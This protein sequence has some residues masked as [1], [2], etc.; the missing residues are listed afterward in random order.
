M[1][2]RPRPTFNAGM[3]L[4]VESVDGT[5]PQKAVNPSYF[6]GGKWFDVTTEDL[7]TLQMQN[8]II[9]PG[10]RAG[11][12]T[13]NNRA[14]VPGRQWVEGGFD[15][16]VDFATLMPLAYAALGSVES[17]AEQSTNFT[18]LSGGSFAGGGSTTITLTSQ[19]S[20]GGAVLRFSVGATSSPGTITV[21]GVDSYGETVEESI[22]YTS[23]G[24]LYTRTSFSSVTSVIAQSD[25]DADVDVHGF[26]YFEHTFRF[27]NASAP[28]LAAEVYG[29]PSTGTAASTF[30]Y[31]GLAN[32]ELTLTNPAEQTD[33]L[34]MGNAAFQGNPNSTC[35][36]GVLNSVSPVRIIP[37]W[38]QEVSR[39]GGSYCQ[40]TN[41]GMTFNGGGRKYF[42]ACGTKRPQGSFWGGAELT[43]SIDI[44]IDNANEYNRWLG[45]SAQRIISKWTSPWKLTASQNQLMSASING[46]Y[47]ENIDRV[48]NNEMYQLSADYRAI[49][50]AVT[51]IL[52]IKIINNVPGEAI[53]V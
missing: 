22:S 15:F 31:T 45:A 2:F 1:A 48:D 18:L 32:Q 3:K 30:M 47:F 37:A 9:F 7:P 4:S 25:G 10:G 43:G 33:G 19:P 38:T 36:A 17:S 44:L 29:D 50:D 34:F 24:S 11:I 26:Q 12:R 27:N 23:A 21:Q 39:D 46:L 35:P 8:T 53:A 5:A 41:F 51:G 42:T 52:S 6:Q 40:V 28:T 13:I 49:P 14:P 16:P 20:E